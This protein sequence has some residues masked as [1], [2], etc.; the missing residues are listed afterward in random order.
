MMSNQS[1][2]SKIV[3]AFLLISLKA[4]AQDPVVKTNQGYIKGLTENG[5]AVFKGIPYAQPPIGNYRF[6]PPIAH[7]PWTDTLNTV[8]FGSSAMQ[9]S[10]P[11]TAGSEDCLYLNLYTPKTD[12]SKRAVVVWVHG[13]SMTNGSG[14]GMNGHAFADKDDIVTI[15]IN[16][17]LGALGFLDMAD[18]SNKY[19]QSGNLGLLDVIA[20]LKWVHENIA[21]FGGDPNRVTIMGESAGAKL[22]SAMMVSYASKGLYEQAIL[23]SG[24]VQCIRDSL[25]AKNARTLLLKQL[26]LRPDDAGKLL[27]MSADSIIKAQAAVC[28]GLSGNSFFGP[29]YDGITIRTDGY[30]YAREGKLSGIKAIIGTNENEGAAFIFKNWNASDPNTTVFR[31]LFRSNAPM[32]AAYYQTRL[33]TDSPY[34]AMIKTLTQYMYQLHSYRFAKALTGAGTPVWVY[35]YRFQNGRQFG[36]R[37]G[38]ELHYIWD[39]AEILNSADGASTAD[40]AKRQLAR[41]LHS[42]WVSFIKTG[43]PN[44]DSIPKWP[45]YN[46]KTRQIILFD[47]IDTVVTLKEVYNDPTFPSPVFILR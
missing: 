32:A 7:T 39:A 4:S 11:G 3:F 33:K 17:R 26:G 24:S 28:D 47:N 12:D 31:P 6:M 22:L 38:D 10:G 13:G 30:E 16:Y 35:R 43:D 21:A 25:T 23:E 20:A 15:T 36:A 45:L 2:L 40:T 18:L 8:Q 46:D 42:A 37:H 41:S 29:V 27:T 14:K 5:I 1:S 9:P 19:A 34:A 44:G